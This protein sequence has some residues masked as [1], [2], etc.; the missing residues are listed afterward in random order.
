MF[1]FMAEAAIGMPFVLLGYANP[2]I[3]TYSSAETQRL[4]HYNA[5]DSPGCAWHYAD[6]ERDLPGFYSAYF[7][8]ADYQ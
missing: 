1:V 2:S 5:G 6:Q 4:S 3:Y 8:F 7:G